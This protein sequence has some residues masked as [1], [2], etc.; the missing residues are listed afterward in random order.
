MLSDAPGESNHKADPRA[1]RCT[2]GRSKPVANGGLPPDVRVASGGRARARVPAGTV[3]RRRP[4]A[5]HAPLG[6]VWDGPC[7]PGGVVAG[8]AACG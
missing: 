1:G 2:A 4:R 7:W 5:G 6:G 3:Q 8:A